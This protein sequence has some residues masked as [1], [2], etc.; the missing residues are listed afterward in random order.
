MRVRRAR[1]GD[2]AAIGRILTAAQ[3]ALGSDDV[4]TA[5]AAAGRW[6]E[7]I[8]RDDQIVR[9]AVDTHGVV[10]FVCAGEPGQIRA[11][12]VHPD[13]QRQGHGS[14]L[15]AAGLDD[16]VALGHPRA[17]VLVEPGDARAIAFYEARGWA[18]VAED[19]LERSVAG[20]RRRWDL[21]ARGTGV[22]DAA[23][24]VP[25]LDRLR[26]ALLAPGWVTEEPDVHLLPHVRRL[27]D[28]QGWEVRR[29]E[30]LDATLE[31]DIAVPGG[32]WRSLRAAGYAL[33]GTFAEPATVIRQDERD[34]DG[35]TL[36]AATGVLEGD[37][38]FAPHGH[39]VRLVVRA[40]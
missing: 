9:V 11:L 38:E 2:A 32:D 29:A 40:G 3:R 7:R 23:A 10:G 12:A 6:A 20:F 31:L 21:D 19:R 26:E 28:D 16:L 17:F 8:D 27:C 30:V 37:S 18:R 13:A 35:L 39:T 36:V 4:E 14:A 24:L 15:L 33:L 1:P 22:A 34:G 5:E 25:D